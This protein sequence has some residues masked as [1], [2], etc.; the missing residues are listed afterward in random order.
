MFGKH[1]VICTS[2][3][4]QPQDNIR[5]IKRTNILRSLLITNK[6]TV[7]LIEQLSVG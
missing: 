4:D 1:A 5:R 2:L 7:G 3:W 6:K